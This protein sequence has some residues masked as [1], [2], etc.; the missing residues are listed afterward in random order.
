MFLSSL[1]NDESSC[2]RAGK[3]SDVVILEERER[4]RVYKTNDKKKWMTA[5]HIQ[6]Q[7]IKKL[8]S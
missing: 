1:H 2:H 6:T 5:I 7:R 8:R 3:A 4:E